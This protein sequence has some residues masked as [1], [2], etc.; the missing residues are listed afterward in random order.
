M[1]INPFKELDESQKQRVLELARERDVTC[2]SCGVSDFA[3]GRAMEMG[4]IWHNEEPG[5]YMVGLRCE[6]CGALTG[7]RLHE[8]EFLR[9]ERYTGS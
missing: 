4:F 8:S 5:T 7:I 6:D 9:E 2:E 1:A 3:V